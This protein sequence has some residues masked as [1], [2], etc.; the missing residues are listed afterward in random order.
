MPRCGVLRGMRHLLV[1]VLALAACTSP[2]AAPRPAPVLVAA[3]QMPSTL[4]DV[5]ANSQRIE[6]LARQAAARGAKI[7]VFPEAALTGYLSQDLRVNWHVPG[8]PLDPAFSGRS[9]AEVAV[10]VPGPHTARF[11]RLAR[12]LGVYLVVPFVERERSNNRYF[13]TACLFGP[14]GKLVLHYRKINPWPYPEDAWATP[15]KRLAVADTPLGRLGL[16]ICF[17]I[18]TEP[19]RLA[20]AGAQILLYPIAWVE[21]R[22]STWFEKSLPDIARKHRVAIVGANWSVDHS[23]H[24]RHWFGAGQSRIIDGR[25]RILARAAGDVGEQ[26]LYVERDALLRSVSI[27]SK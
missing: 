20:A 22:G 3:V 23:R 17:D 9:P 8:R 1:P 2:K 27:R 19:P 5:E 13:N 10:T 14:D 26:I 7:V 24:N 6:R 15:G 12:Q 16:L 11:A 21:D 25:G 18:H 4:G